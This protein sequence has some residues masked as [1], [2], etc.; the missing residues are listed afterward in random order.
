MASTKKITQ[1]S[2][3]S[4][5]RARKK[6]ADAQAKLDVVEAALEADLRGGAV[7]QAGLLVAFIKEWSRRNISWKD[8]C[9]RQLGDEYCDRVLA[10]TK[11]E[12]YSKLV[13]EAA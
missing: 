12:N 7:V 10:A 5:L 8:V 13:V 4:I 9:V 1:K 11:A 6:I 2:L 3:A